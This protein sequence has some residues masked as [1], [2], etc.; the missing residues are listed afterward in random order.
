MIEF[1]LAGVLAGTAISAG[2]AG[3]VNWRLKGIQEKKFSVIPE[4]AAPEPPRHIGGNFTQAA[5]EAPRREIPKEIQDEIDQNADWWDREYHKK[6]A[7]AGARVIARYMTEP[8]EERSANGYVT[9]THWGE[10]RVALAGC[11]CGDCLYVMR[12]T[13]GGQKSILPSESEL[14]NE[15]LPW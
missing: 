13:G 2:L 11:S 8:V 5:I 7:E 6:L 9:V 3:A 14:D 10:E 4:L 1:I 15:E 12:R